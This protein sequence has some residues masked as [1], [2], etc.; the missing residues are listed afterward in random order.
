MK[1]NSIIIIFKIIKW[2]IKTV[3]VIFG[4]IPISRCSSGYS[5]KN[6]KITF[7]GKEITDKSF[8]VLND[9]FAKDSSTAYYKERPF[10]YADVATFKALDEHYAKDK[11]KAYYCDEYR[12]GQ[13][14]YLTKK[15]TIVTVLDAVPVSFVS[16]NE[17]YAKDS[18][19]GYF[20][21]IGFPVKDVTS[22]AFLE[23]EFVKDQYQ[24][25][26]R[27]RPVKDA[28]V[29]TFRVLN[30]CYARDTAQIFYYGFH[31]DLYNGIHK[32]PCKAAS[33][34]MLEYPYSKDDESVFCVYTK[35][36]GA[37]VNSFSVIGNSFSK[38]INHVYMESKMLKDADAATFMIVPHDENS[39]DEFNYTKDKKN[40][41]WKDKMLGELDISA[42]KALG[43]GYATDGKHI[44][45]HAGIV[46]NADPVT[47]KVY[48]NGN[49]DADAEDAKNKYLEGA[50]VVVE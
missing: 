33:F 29:N 41:F 26:F 4:I 48:E 38:D 22:L 49:G 37:D 8:V 23:G 20:K 6:G 3:L 21:G 30:M 27:Q 50:K 12:E 31:S 13:N 44:F 36:A 7:K 43:L 35:I 14:Y 39:L 16:I 5:N 45:Y 34:S 18:K 40:A 42:F 28:D 17:G 2:T 25:Y 47:F 10:N 1:D 19:R 32:I 46:K 15:Q 24:V 9:E 11:D